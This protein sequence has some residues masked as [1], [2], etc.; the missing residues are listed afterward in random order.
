MA[1]K[2]IVDDVDSRS[3]CFVLLNDL[4]QEDDLSSICRYTRTQQILRQKKGKITG[5]DMISMSKDHENGPG[6]NS[7]C[8]HGERYDEETTLSAAVM[9]VNGVEPDKSKISICLG[10][11]CHAW[12]E[13]DGH[14]TIQMD[15]DLNE[16]ESGFLYGDTFKKYYTEEVRW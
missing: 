4:N 16:L 7:I 8:R 14:I 3:N 6:Q 5:N 13:P 12:C 9:E 1:T 2:K 11:P 10:K 15:F